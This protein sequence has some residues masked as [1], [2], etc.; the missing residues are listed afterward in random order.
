MYIYNII[1]PKIFALYICS[2]HNMY[3]YCEGTVACPLTQSVP[4][5][6]SP[7]SLSLSRSLPPFFPLSLPHSFPHSLPHSLLLSL[8]Y[9]LPLFLPIPLSLPHR[10]GQMFWIDSNLFQAEIMTSR[11][12]GSDQ[13]VLVSTGLNS[14]GKYNIYLANIYNNMD[15]IIR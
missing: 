8:L 9:S 4:P 2:I 10:L 3:P 6:P 15:Y 7:I 14:P 5:S 12:D 1:S 13:R 11:L